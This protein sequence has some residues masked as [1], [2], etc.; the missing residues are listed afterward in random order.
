MRGASGRDQRLKFAPAALIDDAAGAIIRRFA[1]R[2]PDLSFLTVLL[3]NLHAAAGFKQALRRAAGRDV[4]LLPR[5]ATLT[6]IAETISLERPIAPS[7]LRVAQIYSALKARDWF[8]SAN[9]WHIS[10]ELAQL[11]DELTFAQ[12][13]LPSTIDEFVTLLEAGYGAKSDGAMRFEARLV[14]EMWYAFNRAEATDPKSSLSAAAAYQLQLASAAQALGGPL[15]VVGVDYLA[16]LEVAFLNQY[17]ERQPVLVINA[18]TL[19]S[20]PLTSCLA[21]A[22]AS[23]REGEP[24]AE[25]LRKRAKQFGRRHARSPLQESPKLYGAVSLE[26]EAIAATRQIQMWLVEGKRNIALLAMDRLAARRVR[27]LLER[28]NILLA[29]ESGWTLSTTSAS[30]VVMR[31][32]DTISDGFYHRDVL[33]L[34]KSPFF[35]TD[36]SLER[37]KRAVHRLEKWVREHGIVAG[38][39]RYRALVARL[40]P[41]G[42]ESEIIDRLEHAQVRFR[43]GRQ[44]IA[45]WIDRLLDSLGVLGAALG[46]EA[47]AAGRQLLKLL[48]QRRQ[49]LVGHA[50]R[51][52]LVEWR[53]WLNAELE[54]ATFRDD[55]IVSPVVL[56]S[57]RTTRLREFEAAVLIGADATNLSARPST[58][59]L[60][61]QSVRRDLGLPSVAETA[62]EIQDDLIGLIARSGS[63]LV[64]WQASKDGE[65]NAVSPWFARLEAFHAMAYDESLLFRPTE[66]RALAQTQQDAPFCAPTPAVPLPLLPTRISASGYAS[67]MAC[68]YQFFARHVLELNEQD[69]VAEEME[70][71]DYGELV[72]KILASFHEQYPSILALAEDNAEAALRRV[73]NAV[74]DECIANNYTGIAWKFR[75][76]KRIPAYLAWQRQRE[77]EGW[78]F[79]DAEKKLERPFALDHGGEVTLHG[80]IDRVDRHVEGDRYA[81]LDYKT[82]KRRLLADKLIQ[83]GEDM[84]LAVYALLRGEQTTDAAYVSLDEEQKVVVVPLT[85]ALPEVAVDAGRRLSELFNGMVH[86]EGLPANGA[87][88][89]CR[90]C[91][92]RGL[93]RLD[94]WTTDV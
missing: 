10:N 38:L 55:A 94:Y 16:A 52:S 8:D 60:F 20:D 88:H 22:W 78:S 80:R 90:Y 73:T 39:D 81:V 9:L 89:V 61:N 4:L 68:P 33:D 40:A 46:L 66:S 86:G 6:S 49:E 53:Q 41:G 83:R 12:Q 85:E 92:M 82:Q 84:Q 63:V 69:E 79:E 3:P 1:D 17:A 93:C 58:F 32:L 59:R 5:F 57:L 36:W 27:A 13:G 21:T 2:L 42:D 54:A 29:D 14:H 31:F 65:H 77:S 25:E 11:F 87:P 45:G 70:K 15:C 26:D 56:T 91:E 35:A 18:D 71:R 44:A 7:S 24:R 72:H 51:I 67:L 43:T 34:A 75:W 47:D 48:V 50:E 28:E 76:E 62:A 64:T 74:F 19:A 37:R 23:S 30:T